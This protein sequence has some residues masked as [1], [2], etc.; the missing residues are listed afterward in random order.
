MSVSEL[1][2]GSGSATRYSALLGGYDGIQDGGKDDGGHA[3]SQIL[4]NT[5]SGV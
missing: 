5:V 4:Q 2:Q 3:K 1:A